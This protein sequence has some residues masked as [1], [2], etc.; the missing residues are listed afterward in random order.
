M[1]W[2]VESCFLAELA[3]G[4]SACGEL[5]G[6][7]L[8]HR[9]DPAPAPN[10]PNRPNRLKY[11][12]PKCGTSLLSVHLPG[13]CDVDDFRVD[14]KVLGPLFETNFLLICG[15]LCHASN[16]SCNPA[17]HESIGSS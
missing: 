4:F 3:G 16:F 10:R 11:H 12:V 17:N 5:C 7:D 14:K 15:Q 2:T 8:L 6:E 13:L 1:R 9:L